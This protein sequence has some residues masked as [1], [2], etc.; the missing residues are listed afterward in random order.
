MPT[1]TTFVDGTVPVAADFNNNFTALNQVCG[2]TTAITGYTAGDLLYASA[3]TALSKLGI[4][5]AG[6]ILG[7]SSGLPAWIAPPASWQLLPVNAVF[8]SSNFAAL[9]KNAGTNWVDYTLDFDQTTGESAYWE[10]ALPAS[11]S[12][13]GATIEIFSRQAAATSGT[14]GWTVTTLTR[15]DGE[16]WDTAGNADTVTADAVEG[17]AGMVHRQT[18]DLTTTGW[19]ASEILLIK[20]T[21]DVA[22][23]TVAEDAKLIGAVLRLT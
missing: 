12:L 8:P 7:V 18:K 2:T 11:V 23:D 14:V 6:K 9:T 15:A 10:I 4:G 5:A 16:A 13:S 19:A 22:N 20:I 1:M 3:T 21:R 17:T